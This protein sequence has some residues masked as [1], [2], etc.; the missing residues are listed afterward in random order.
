[1]S[2]V[3]HFEGESSNHC[4]FATNS[5]RDKVF[6]IL[7]FNARSILPKLDELKIITENS[8]PD[9]V[10][11]TE[12]WLSQ[13]ISDS[14]MS[15][16]GYRDKNRQ[17]G[18]VLVYTRESLHIKLPTQPPP[19]LELLTLFV[20]RNNLRFCIALFYR[21]PSSSVEVFGQVCSYFDTLSI[22]Q[23][24]NFIFLGNFNVNIKDQS[25][26]YYEN[27]CDIMPFYSLS[28]V[29][30]DVTHIHHN[31]TVSTIDLVLM[32][33][34]SQLIKCGSIPPLFNSDH[35]GLEIA[36]KWRSEVCTN[37]PRRTIWR[38]AHADWGKANDLIRASNWDSFMTD[39]V[40]SSW[41]NWQREFLSIMD[42]CIPKRLLPPGRNLPWLIQELE[43]GH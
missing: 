19:G 28:Q 18:G 26:L 16:P 35:N 41:H 7:Y 6:K 31:G 29:V 25:H 43:T 17:G 5:D 39:D 15:I 12:T 40:S 42:Q 1:M 10:C 30:D 8:N 24:S 32:T 37:R 13:E 22:S 33:T 3:G 20:Y 34:P 2:S 38:Y 21:P 36:V 27:L 9:V 14:E 4:H 23:F 11:I